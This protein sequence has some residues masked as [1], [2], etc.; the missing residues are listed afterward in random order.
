M[1]NWY[2]SITTLFKQFCQL[3]RLSFPISTLQSNDPIIFLFLWVKSIW[4]TRIV[5]RRNAWQIYW[6]YPRETRKQA[7]T[8][9][10]YSGQGTRKIVEYTFTHRFA[11][12]FP[13][14]LRNPATMKFAIEHALFTQIF[15]LSPTT[16]TRNRAGITRPGLIWL[17]YCCS[18]VPSKPSTYNKLLYIFGFIQIV[19]RIGDSCPS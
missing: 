2:E 9:A 11:Q 1:S 13:F 12:N 15:R 7:Q 14:P 6:L 16:V 5:R 10:G 8:N 19:I 17:P 3:E 4:T 18:A